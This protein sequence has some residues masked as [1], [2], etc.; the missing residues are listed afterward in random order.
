[1]I[2]G[3]WN[4]LKHGMRVLGKS[5][6]FTAVAV[7]SLALGVGASTAIF[8]VASSLL[9]KSLPFPNANRIAIIWQRSPGLNVAQDWLSLGQYV[10]IANDNTVFA[11]VAAAIGASVNLTGGNAPERIDGMRVSSSFFQLF[12]PRVAFGRSFS[13]DDD[14]PGR[15]PIV[16]LN[17]GF[18]RRRFGGDRGIIGKILTLNGTGFTIVGV[19]ADDF[20][21][22]EK[23]CPQ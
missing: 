14:R 19:M 20:R 16:I 4:D 17:H 1:V 7:L 15:T 6:A 9:F 11:N 22:K 5:R 23:S 12:G 8:S 21:F 3:W 13:V 2:D 18:W 10:D